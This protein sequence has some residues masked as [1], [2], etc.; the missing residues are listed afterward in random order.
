MVVTMMDAVV[1]VAVN[2]DSDSAHDESRGLGESRNDSG[3][4]WW[5]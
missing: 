4:K 5:L 2:R 3:G 1:M